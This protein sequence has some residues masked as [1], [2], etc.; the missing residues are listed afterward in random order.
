[1]PDHAGTLFSGCAG[2]SIR[3]RR[4]WHA[5]NRG[6]TEPSVRRSGG[7]F[8]ST[9]RGCAAGSGKAGQA[10]RLDAESAMQAR[11]AGAVAPELAAAVEAAFDGAWFRRRRPYARCGFST[12][13]SHVTPLRTGPDDRG[14]LYASLVDAYALA[15]QRGSRAQAHGGVGGAATRRR[16]RSR[17]SLDER[18]G[19]AAHCALAA[20]DY[21]EAQRR[22]PRRRSSWAARVCDPPL[23]GRALDLGGAPDSAIAVYER[24]LT[25]PCPRSHGSGMAASCPPSTS[26]WAS[27]TKQRASAT[28]R[29]ST[30]ASFIDLWKNADR[31][32]AAAGAGCEAAGRG[33]DERDGYSVSW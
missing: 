8:R 17:D 33:A 28:R 24:Y 21:A 15:G 14:T 1:M 32:A 19:C 26:G 20:K 13:R 29:W 30:I 5:P 27:C 4:R 12:T 2:N 16:R 25:T 9:S 3:G 22:A 31:G 23:L 11:L 6:S 18:T 10:A 7:G